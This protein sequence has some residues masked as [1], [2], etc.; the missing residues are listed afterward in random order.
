MMNEDGEQLSLF[1]SNLDSKGDVGNG[2]DEVEDLKEFRVEMKID[3][4][5]LMGMRFPGV[6]GEMSLKL[7]DFL[8]AH[9]GQDF[10]VLTRDE[11]EEILSGEK[12]KVMRSILGVHEIVLN[13]DEDGRT[14]SFI[15]LKFGNER[16]A[17]GFVKSRLSTTNAIRTEF[18][19]PPLGQE[20]VGQ[21]KG[22]FYK[23]KR[24]RRN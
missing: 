17:E 18:G 24:R 8:E 13:F 5:T 1:P 16:E 2:E 9:L 7:P 23:G 22:K 21:R 15:E 11:V 19:L 6:G 20:E 14:L 3:S 10:S 4:L 12:F